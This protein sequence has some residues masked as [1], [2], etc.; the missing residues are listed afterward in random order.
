MP[1]G[2]TCLG[3]DFTAREVN[4]LEMRNKPLVLPGGKR[5]EE[6]IIGCSME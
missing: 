3:E 1:Y 2:I 5:R 4:P 6:P